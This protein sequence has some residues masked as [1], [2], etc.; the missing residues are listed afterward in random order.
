MIP[1]LKRE[2][3]MSGSYC[4]HLQTY[5]MSRDSGGTLL[6]SSTIGLLHLPCWPPA[7]LAKSRPLAWCW[8]R[9]SSRSTRCPEIFVDPFPTCML[10]SWPIL[11][12]S[13]KYQMITNN[14]KDNK[15]MTMIT[16]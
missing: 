13:A 10:V 12:T 6:S 2:G 7:G 8:Q 15:G 9:R 4:V 5:D 14:N 3:E 11:I 16:K 1:R